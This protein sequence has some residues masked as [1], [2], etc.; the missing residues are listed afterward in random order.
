MK[1]FCCTLMLLL[2]P[3]SGILIGQNQ[4]PDGDFESWTPQGIGLYEEPS[5][6]WWSTLNPLRALGGPVS[7][8]KST[9]AH[10]GTYSALLTTGQFG[11]LLVPGL[12][13]SA[14]FDILNAPNYFDQGRPY[15]D[16][17]QTFTGWYKYTPANGDT[18]AIGMQVTRWN[19]ATNKRDTVGE[20]G[21]LIVNTVTNWTQ[22]SIPVFYYNS[23]TPDTLLVVASSS[24][25]GSVGGGQVG[26]VLAIDD[27]DLSGTAT[28]AP[29]PLQALQLAFVQTATEWQLDAGNERGKLE[30]V[31][32]SGKVL[33]T[34]VVHPGQNNISHSELPNGI[35]LLRFVAD[36]GGV[37]F[38]KA[39]LIR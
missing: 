31:D 16:R 10:S 25:N 22:F 18:A 12:L 32:L 14:Q 21:I 33:K 1:I 13:I 3:F 36:K 27:F 4:I 20:A 17:P 34:A 30:V 37:W 35:F 2:G 19:T 6:G 11:S 38:K 8:E 28:A 29:N 9:D 26:S 24:A 15:T 39:H 5:S 23:D 7:V